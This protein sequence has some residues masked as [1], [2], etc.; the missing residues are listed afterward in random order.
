MSA[1]V[2]RPDLSL[3]GKLRRRLVRLSHRRAAARGPARGMV[4][5]SFDDAPDS[6]T[7]LGADLLEAQGVRATYFV[8][9]GLAGTTAHLGR[10]ADR[11]EVRRLAARGH[12]VASHTFSHL[13][14]G[15]VSPGALAA[16]LD[17]N[18]RAFAEW[19]L[20][21][22]RTFAYPYGDVSGPTKAVAASRFALCRG[23]HA[24]LVGRGGDLNQA[25]SVAMDG[26]GGEA[27]ARAALERA[28]DRR[29]WVILF[30]HQVMPGVGE[31]AVSPD[32]LTR[33]AELARGL[34]LDVVTAAEGALALA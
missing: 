13:D 12:E 29:E 28:D 26:A 1:E 31:F 25:P 22:A 18:A 15:R 11:D 21:P 23:V 7:G 24:G 8:A 19:G 3:R 17:R 32:A 20:P 27:R 9:A 33:L 6:A 30:A 4:T 34:G 10:Y 16:D 14:C 5:F 2:Y